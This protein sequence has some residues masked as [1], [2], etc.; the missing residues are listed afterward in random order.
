MLLPISH[1]EAAFPVKVSAPA[2]V[3]ANIPELEVE[4]V[5]FPEVFVQ[6]EVPPEASDS[7][8]VEFPILV[9]EVPVALI[10]AVPLFWVNAPVAV[11]VP[12]IAVVIAALPILIAE[13]LL[14]P[15]D[16]VPFVPPVL[17]PGSM[18][19]A[20]EFPDVVVPVLILIAPDAPDVPP[21]VPDVIVIAPPVPVAP[22]APAV[23]AKAPPAPDPTPAAP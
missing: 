20:P 18:V 16:N 9:A 6:D 2:E 8:P 12:V 7:A 21:P 5:K 10:L 1:V 14:V 3:R 23:K 15:S 4:I 11:S 22:A 13:A 19:M 17:A